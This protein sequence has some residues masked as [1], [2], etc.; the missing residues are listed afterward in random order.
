M[1]SRLYRAGIMEMA[2][3]GDIYRIYVLLVGKQLFMCPVLVWNI[4]IFLQH[5]LPLGP[6]LRQSPRFRASVRLHGGNNHFHSYSGSTQYSSAHLEHQAFSLS[7]K[8]EMNCLSSK[9][10]AA[11]MRS[12]N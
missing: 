10:G 1:L 6:F 9:N 7:V 8:F 2:W 3:Q 5:L 12:S 4:I 11:C